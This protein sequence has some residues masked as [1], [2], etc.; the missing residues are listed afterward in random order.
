[1]QLNNVLGIEPNSALELRSSFLSALTC[2]ISGGILPVKE[3]PERSKMRKKERLPRDGETV[4]Y[5][6]DWGRII[7]TT[8]SVFRLHQIPFQEHMLFE[9]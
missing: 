5:N 9:L 2:P 1:V 6:P 3:F 8:R 4:P 7:A